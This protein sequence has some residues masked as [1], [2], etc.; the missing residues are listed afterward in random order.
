VDW[1]LSLRSASVRKV[2]SESNQKPVC[3]VI[4]KWTYSVLVF[5]MLELAHTKKSLTPVSLQPAKLIF[6]ILTFG[7]LSEPGEAMTDYIF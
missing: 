1:L 6:T 4:I 3:I 7:L 2:A 5:A